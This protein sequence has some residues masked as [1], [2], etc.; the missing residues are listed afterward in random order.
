[1]HAI[2]P[3]KLSVSSVE[4]ATEAAQPTYPILPWERQTKERD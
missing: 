2:Q 1:M 4:I 3:L